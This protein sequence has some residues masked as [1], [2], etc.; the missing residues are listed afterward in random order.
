MDKNKKRSQPAMSPFAEAILESISDGVFTVDK[1]WNVTSFNRAAEEI[2]GILREEA[3]GRR[4]SD[5]FRSSMCETDCALKR[6][7]ETGRPVVNRSCYIIDGEGERI[8]ISV[9]T[10]VLKDEE[11]H[12]IGGAETFRDLT[13]VEQLRQ[14]LDERHRIGELISRSPSMKPLF[15]M[16]PAVA[17]SGGTVLITGESGTGKE[18][19]AR[20]MHQIS[21]RKEGPFITVNCGALPDNLLESELFGY[22]AGAFTGAVKDKPGRFHL[23]RGGTIFLDEIGELSPTMQVKLLRVLQDKTFEPLGGTQTEKSDARVIAA[24]NR[25]LEEEV[26]A[27]RFREDLFYRINVI[28]LHLPPLRERQEDI[29]LLTEQFIRLFN[30]RGKNPMQGVSPEVYQA[31]LSYGWP[32]NIREL[33]NVIERAFILCRSSVI[34]PDLLPPE[35]APPGPP[36]D[37]SSLQK[38]SER[39]EA[40]LLRDVLERNGG[41]KVKAARELGIHKSTLY[42][43]LKRLGLGN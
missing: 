23:A 5:V 24:T 37:T 26:K 32:G 20:T 12:I 19:L 25:D 21:P 34:T 29:P 30:S 3:I 2:T 9:S 15:E 22:K 35:L 28:R 11:G 8:P 6:T 40:S 31:F 41:D 1:E 27:G 14:E 42:R 33:E 39:V 7:I 17:E 4:C 36:R 16:L 10:A 13:E 38:A 43:K 18:V